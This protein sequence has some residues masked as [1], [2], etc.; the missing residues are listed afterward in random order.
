MLFSNFDWWY[1]INKSRLSNRSRPK[2]PPSC[3]ERIK[4]IL[5]ILISSYIK[6]RQISLKRKCR[7]NIQQKLLYRRC[8]WRLFKS[9]IIQWNLFQTQ[10]RNAPKFSTTIF[11]CYVLCYNFNARELLLSDV[12]DYPI[13]PKLRLFQSVFVRIFISFVGKGIKSD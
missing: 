4:S 10:I 13:F 1:W 5:E 8:L 7:S 9:W 6:I 3:R 12:L 2:M 11:A